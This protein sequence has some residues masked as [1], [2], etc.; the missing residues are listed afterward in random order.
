MVELGLESGTLI[1][2]FHAFNYSA[3]LHKTLPFRLPF[4][5]TG[6]LSR[7]LY[8]YPYKRHYKTQA[9]FPIFVQSLRLIIIDRFF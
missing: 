2:D 4:H 7:R 8:I 9:S 5:A 3:T 6:F 1:S